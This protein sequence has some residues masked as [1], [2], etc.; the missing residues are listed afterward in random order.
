MNIKHTYVYKEQE[1]E[2]CLWIKKFS[3][4]L[5]KI[6]RKYIKKFFFLIILADNKNRLLYSDQIPYLSASPIYNK[7]LLLLYS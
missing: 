6:V 3:L 1:K 7:I 2:K 4:F 5:S